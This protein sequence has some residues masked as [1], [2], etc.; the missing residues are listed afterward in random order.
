MILYCSLGITCYWYNGS[1][2]I[3]YWKYAITR[4][5]VRKKEGE[6]KERRKEKKERERKRE[7]KEE[8][9]VSDYERERERERERIYSALQSWLLIYDS[10]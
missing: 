5:R 7:G 6:M 10:F 4:E 2:V 1:T 9:R 8:R 3:L